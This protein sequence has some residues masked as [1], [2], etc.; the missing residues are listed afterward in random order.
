MREIN[1][2]THQIYL[3]NTTDS[4]V[5]CSVFDQYAKTKEYVK[6]AGNKESAIFSKGEVFNVENISI[7]MKGS[8]GNVTVKVIFDSNKQ[9]R[10]LWHRYYISY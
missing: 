8:K 4:I 7:F 5:E 2:H 1:R 3:K 10:Y 9:K 6:V